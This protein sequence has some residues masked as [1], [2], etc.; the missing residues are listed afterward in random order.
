VD[1]QELHNANL[2]KQALDDI[3]DLKERVLWL[4]LLLNKQPD[5][6]GE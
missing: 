5:K 3:K 4:E 2:F 6:Q 1:S